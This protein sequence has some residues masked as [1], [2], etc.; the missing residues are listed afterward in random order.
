LL[1]ARLARLMPLFQSAPAGEGGRC[2]EQLRWTVGAV[3]SIR[4]RR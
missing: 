3:V 4:A 2:N 1:I